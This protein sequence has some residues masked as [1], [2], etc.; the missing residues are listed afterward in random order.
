[1]SARATGG[2]RIVHFGN[3]SLG[4]GGIAS[5]LRQ[6]TSWQWAQTTHEARDTYEGAKR[7]KGLLRLL[8]A[9]VTIF[10]R[11]RRID[12]AHVHLSERGSFLRE[13]SVVLLCSSLS[14][15]TVVTLHGA[16]FKAFRYRCPRL[17]RSVLDRADLVVSLYQEMAEDLASTGISAPV[18]V[19][20]NAVNEVPGRVVSNVGP[21]RVVFAGEL[22]RRKGIDTLLDAW[23][24]VRSEVGATLHVF[25]PVTDEFQQR[26]RAKPLPPGVFVHGATPHSDVLE[27]MHRASLFV[28]PSRAEAFPMA[29]LEAMAIGLPVVATEVAG[30]PDML[31]VRSQLVQPE[32]AEQLATSLVRFLRDEHLLRS[33][34]AT[35]R[36]RQRQLFSPGVVMQELESHYLRVVRG[37]RV[38]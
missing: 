21:P 29:I 31:A 15:P 37:E 16:S 24:H 7:S 35:N 22:S 9:L 10:V 3:Y 27:H 30:V 8:P 34:G 6:Y 33:A 5:V 20:P 14:I 32:D 38:S 18:V 1:V 17:V 11:Q 23:P 26:L 12:V 19:I 13:G 2:L 28:L 4:G 25:G 36:M